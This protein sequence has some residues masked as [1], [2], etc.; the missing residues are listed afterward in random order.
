MT[1]ETNTQNEQATG[2]AMSSS[3]YLSCK[4]SFSL[5]G[6][7]HSL[8]GCAYKHSVIPR[9]TR[10]RSGWFRRPCTVVISSCIP[11][12]FHD[13]RDTGKGSS[14]GC[15]SMPQ[16]HSFSCLPLKSTF[17]FKLSH[18]LSMLRLTSLRQL[19]DPYSSVLGRKILPSRDSPITVVQPA[20]V[21]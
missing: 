14:P 1:G 8:P 12:E 3:Y 18:C 13:R 17:E 10:A 21:D 6:V 4:S 9:I 11:Q 5:W 7:A 2:N 15:C 19:A 20:L 16:G